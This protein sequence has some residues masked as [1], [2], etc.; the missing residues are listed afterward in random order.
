[1]DSAP[2]LTKR[3]KYGYN[4]SAKFGL[5]VKEQRQSNKALSAKYFKKAE[6]YV[7]HTVVTHYHRVY[8]NILSAILSYFIIVRL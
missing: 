5:L 6:L 7:V 8:N 2:G 1:M 4:K 3:L